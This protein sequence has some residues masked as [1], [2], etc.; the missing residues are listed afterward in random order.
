MIA[1]EKNDSTDEYAAL[2][3]ARDKGLISS[4]ECSESTVVLAKRDYAAAQAKSSE[5][6]RSS[7]AAELKSK[8]DSNALARKKKPK[9]SSLVPSSSPSVTS[10]KVR[11]NEE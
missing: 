11:M 4:K 9:V 10:P 3:W 5:S 6:I 2:R 7:P 1:G 8:A